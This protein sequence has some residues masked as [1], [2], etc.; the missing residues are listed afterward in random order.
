MEKPFLNEKYP[1]LHTSPEVEKAVERHEVR[2]DEDVPNDPA[3]RTEIY[4][5]RLEHVFLHPDEEKRERNINLLRDVIHNEFV[6]KPEEVPEGYFELQ[7]RIAKE[8]GH[9]DIEITDEQRQE[10]IKTII[11]DQAKSLDNWIDYLTSNDAFY[12]TWLKYYAFR[13]IIRL[14]DYDKEKK[15]FRKRS[16]GTTGLF[17]DINRE[18]LAYVLD[19]LEKKYENK[20][21]VEGDEKFQ[22][23][24]DSANFAKLYAYAIEE[25]TPAS[26]EQK[27]VIKGQWVKFDE[28]SDP[29]PLYTSLQ[30]HGTGWCTAGEST[31]KAQ[32]EKGD[33]YVF[34]TEDEEGKNS[35]PRIAIRMEEGRIAEVR[36]INKDQNLEPKLTDIAQEKMKELPGH[37]AYEKKTADMKWLT[38]IEAKVKNVEDLTKEDLIFL[39]EM[40][41]LISGFGYTIDPRIEEIRSQR[42]ERADIAFVFDW[43]CKPEQISL[44]EKEAL[45][46]GILYHYGELDLSRAD[47]VE[48]IKLPD[49]I[50]GDLNLNYQPLIDGLVLPKYV[51][52]NPVF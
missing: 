33:F 43:K 6:I 18:A 52:G 21:L 13:N 16:K 44:T 27:E 30:G 15:E 14:S 23:L 24:L 32:L 28:G 35:I 22:K 26:Q 1:D 36:G 40:K 41:D 25:C 3:E 4:L 11:Q 5:K 51:G 8:R 47:S 49:H 29:T 2:E 12:P 38:A 39:Y 7:K 19:A 48:N 50:T 31:A 37:E 34:Y 45:Q 20:E 46:E 9:G 10:M 42:N 17:P